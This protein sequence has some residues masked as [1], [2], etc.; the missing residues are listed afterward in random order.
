MI[1]FIDQ[2]RDRFGGEFLC[3]V[4]RPAVRGF[5]TARGYHAA[6]AR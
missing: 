4:L 3:R 6:K 2:M 1:A 5:L